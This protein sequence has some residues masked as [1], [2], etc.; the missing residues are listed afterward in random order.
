MT[1]RQLIGILLAAERDKKIIYR[2][3]A[4]KFLEKLQKTAQLFELFT[5]VTYRAAYT[6]MNGRKN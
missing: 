4:E 3:I 5:G 2:Y 1:P 6:G